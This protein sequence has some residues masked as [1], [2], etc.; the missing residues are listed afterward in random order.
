MG[1]RPNSPPQTTRVESSKPLCFKSLMSAA[2]GLSV[3]PHAYRKT[4]FEIAVRI[5][6]L[7]FYIELH[8]AYAALHKPA[9]HQ[10][11]TS[12]RRCRRIVQTVSF[13]RCFTLFADIERSGGF[14]LHTS[15][16]FITGYPRI[17]FRLVRPAVPGELHRVS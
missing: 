9:S 17:Q 1:R 13:S 5:E 10:A 6:D 4:A 3:L 14:Q 16:Q 15:G 2:V 7:P 8:K 11:S 12:V